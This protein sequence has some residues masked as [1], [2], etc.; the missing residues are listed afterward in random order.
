MTIDPPI[1]KTLRLLQ[2][3]T[4]QKSGFTVV[5]K[6]FAILACLDKIKVRSRKPWMTSHA[7]RDIAGTLVLVPRYIG[8]ILLGK[9]K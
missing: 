2:L 6:L 8:L 3:T 7:L 9:K 4:E 1:Y 5:R